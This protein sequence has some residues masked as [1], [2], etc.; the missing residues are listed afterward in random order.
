MKKQ[1]KS[2]RYTNI[3]TDKKIQKYVDFNDILKKVEL[4]GLA[5]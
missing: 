3:D 1:M 5:K 2:S 4:V